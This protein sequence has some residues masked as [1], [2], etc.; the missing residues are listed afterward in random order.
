MAS[1]NL[2][3]DR[4]SDLRERIVRR[5]LRD[6]V[7]GKI[8]NL[9]AG[10]LLK[11]GDDLP[12][13]RDLATALQVSRES[14]RGGIQIL[15]AK[16]LVAVVHGARTRVLSETVGAEFTRARE[17]RLL[18]A[19]G[20][21]DIHAARLIA[22]RPVVGD[23]AA[24]MDEAT[25]GFLRD[26]LA[27]QRAAP[28]D[29]VR[30]LISD[31]EFHLAVYDA[32][33]NAVLADFVADLYGY[34]IEARRLAVSEPGAIARSI[35]DHATIL[36]A[37]EAGDRAATERAFDVHIRHIFDSTRRILARATPPRAAA[38]AS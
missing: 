5:N 19:Y 34:M 11:V 4:S 2:L 23:A 14:V 27:A 38:S 8:A 12:G 20:L 6:V 22:E 16:G 9:I 26:C 30:F 36:A 10:G 32:C 1:P 28:T 25:L 18:D 24:R 7:A 31:R 13:E 17:P 33:G 15:A 21:D 3:L 29:P 37:L 35:E